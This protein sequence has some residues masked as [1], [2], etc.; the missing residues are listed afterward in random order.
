MKQSDWL[1]SFPQRAGFSHPAR[2]EMQQARCE[3][4]NQILTIL[5]SYVKEFKFKLKFNFF[6]KIC[7]SEYI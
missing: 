4:C 7:T 1:R 6:H 5:F 2:C 3:K